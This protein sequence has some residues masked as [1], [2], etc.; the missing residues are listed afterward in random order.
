MRVR[1]SENE[2]DTHW[3]WDRISRLFHMVKKTAIR[4][5]K[6]RIGTL[7]S[8]RPY[9]LFVRSF[10]RRSMIFTNNS[11]VRLALPYRCQPE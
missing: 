10:I 3:Q 1:E 2:T 7:F 4:S 6:S 8:G 5:L 11:L 9:V